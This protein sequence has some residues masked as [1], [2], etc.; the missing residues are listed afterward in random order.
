MGIQVL[1]IGEVIIYDARNNRYEIKGKRS[2]KYIDFD[3]TTQKLNQKFM[4]LTELKEQ[5]QKE[6]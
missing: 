2:T 3:G 1:N 6:K 5:M 4:I